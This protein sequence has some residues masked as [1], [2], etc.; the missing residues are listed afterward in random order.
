LSKVAESETKTYDT[1]NSIAMEGWRFGNQRLMTGWR[2]GC[3]IT[4]VYVYFKAYTISVTKSSHAKARG[5]ELYAHFPENRET[6]NP[7]GNSLGIRNPNSQDTV[8]FCKLTSN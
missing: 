3:I 5:N 1:N 8:L 7:D 2:V 4:R 6:C